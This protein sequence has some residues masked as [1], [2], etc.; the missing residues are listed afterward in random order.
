MA[1]YYA[2]G[3]NSNQGRVVKVHRNTNT[4][5]WSSTSTNATFFNDSISP[6]ASGSWF[7]INWRAC[8]SHS[9]NYSLYIQM[10]VGGTVVGGRGGGSYQSCG[11]SKYNENYGS[12]HLFNAGY[13]QYSG[14]YIHTTTNSSSWT[15]QLRT[16]SQ[17]GTHYFNYAYGYNDND[18]GYPRAEYYILECEGS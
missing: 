17:G 1:I 14:Q 2:A 18:R 10:L 9:T 12:G 7:I 6:T 8:L 15:F 3:G 13:W 5:T 4:T 16:R 11:Q